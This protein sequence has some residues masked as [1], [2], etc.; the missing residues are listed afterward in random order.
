MIDLY[1]NQIPLL[2]EL[3]DTEQDP[4]W[5]E[6]GNVRVH[7][8]M[9]L[10]ELEK[11]L[12][13]D[14]SYLSD[15]D[16]NV[17]RHAALFHDIGKTTRTRFIEKDDKK[18][19]ISPGHA[20]SGRNYLAFRLFGLSALSREDALK[21][22]SL[23]A[24]H[25]HPKRLV[26]K[27]QPEPRWSRLAR[28]VPTELVYWLEI[29]DIKGRICPDED[30]LLDYMNLYRMEMKDLGYWS[31]EVIDPYE[32]WADVFQDELEGPD[33]YLEFVKQ[34]AALNY[35]AGRIKSPYEA[36]GRAKSVFPPE[37]YFSLDV[38]CALSGSGKSTWAGKQGK[39]VVS[40]DAIREQITGDPSDQSQN[41]KVLQAAKEQLKSYLRRNK[42]VIWDA[43]NTRRDF[44]RVPIQLGFDYGAH[45][46]IRFWWQEA[47]K[48]R[49]QNKNR[50]RSVDGLVIDQQVASFQWPEKTEAHEVC[51]Q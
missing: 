33:K 15:S 17:L 44:R 23:V 37:D 48:T 5:H 27:D 2:K 14:A 10:D 25:H 42:D 16:K 40:M 47:S 31:N 12:E 7:T 3:E 45:T 19:V 38:T 20:V 24:Y 34:N 50:S 6:E 18:R 35:E 39:P 32:E 36:I 29:A 28:L 13:A 9:V 30:S 43:T 46:K 51:F 4:I 49:E 8:E 26:T 11:L 21:V 41:G 22:L 1:S